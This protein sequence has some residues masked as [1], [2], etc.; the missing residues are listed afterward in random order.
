MKPSFL[1]A[2]KRLPQVPY[3]I[4]VRTGVFDRREAAHG[5]DAAHGGDLVGRRV[6][7]GLGDEID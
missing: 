3:I 5:A 7:R 4:R 2:P 1:P 6:A